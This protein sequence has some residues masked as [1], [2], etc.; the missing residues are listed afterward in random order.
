LVDAVSALGG[1][2]LPVDEWGLDLVCTS[3][4]KALEIPPGLGIVSVSERA[5]A[6]ID[7]KAT[8]SSRGRYYNLSTWKPYRDLSP[9]ARVSP[10]TTATSLVVALRASLKRILEEETLEGHWSRYAWAQ[11]VARAGLRNI[12]FA[13][14]VSDADASP[15]VTAFWKRDDMANGQ[16]LQEYMATRHGY[17]LAGGLGKLSGQIVRLGHMGKSSTSEYLIPCLLGIEEFLRRSKGVDLPTGASLVGLQT[18]L[19]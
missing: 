10:A 11:R 19:E 6:Q 16:E 17:M 1:Y 2:N 18:G 4:N 13:M 15:T 8:Q 14:L 9:G 12:G 3:S 5:W 7:A